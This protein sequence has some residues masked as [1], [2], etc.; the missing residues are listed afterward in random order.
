M[1]KFNNN[2]VYALAAYNA[3][4][5]NVS[6]YQG[7]P[8]FA[9]TRNYVLKVMR[10]YTGTVID[11]PLP[12]LA[13]LKGRQDK[14]ERS[15]ISTNVAEAPEESGLNWKI[16]EAKFKVAGPK[17]KLPLRATI[18]MSKIPEAVRQNP[19]VTRLL[20]KQTVRAKLLP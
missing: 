14:I 8:P 18:I 1:A 20:A 16:S 13:A 3:G 11:I 19:E 6:K 10:D 7:C 2:V 17:W 4:P 12:A 5:D 15:A 9:E